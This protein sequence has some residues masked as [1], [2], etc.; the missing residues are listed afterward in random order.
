MQIG[1]LL[2][3]SSFR[4]GVALLALGPIV[5]VVVDRV[6]SSHAVYFPADPDGGVG[7]L[8][9]LFEVLML[10]LRVA[11]IVCLLLSTGSWIKRLRSVSTQ[12]LRIAPEDLKR[13]G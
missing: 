10:A 12:P 4:V 1:A 5:S 9:L 2:R 7:L 6:V 8:A 13:S 3:S 11:G